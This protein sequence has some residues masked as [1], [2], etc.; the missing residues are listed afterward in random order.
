MTDPGVVPFVHVGTGGGRHAHQREIDI[1]SSASKC[2]IS[3][4]FGRFLD[5]K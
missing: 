1:V 2:K 4:K 3:S 5:Y